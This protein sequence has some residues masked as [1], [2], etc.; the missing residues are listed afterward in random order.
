MCSAVIE[1]VGR[2]DVLVNNAARPSSADWRQVTHEEWNET[3]QVNLTA[4]FLLARES[5]RSMVPRRWGRIIN[6][7]SRTVRAGGP[8][9]PSYVSS[10]AGLVGL[11]RS[12]ARQ[13]GRFGVTVN[14]VSPGAIWTENEGELYPHLGPDLRHKM[15]TRQQA[16]KRRLR[17]ED[18]AAL[19]SYL[20]SDA[21]EAMTGQTIDVDG[22]WL[23]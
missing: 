13:V 23:S 18:V 16:L 1:Q 4:P 21:A 20:V 19:T 14:A 17:A 12:L 5:L 8:S 7:S 6:I 22:G 15:A 9:G 10:K 3:I 11:T 2:I